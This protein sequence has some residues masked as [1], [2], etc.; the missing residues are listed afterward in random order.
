MSKKETIIVLSVGG[1]LVVPKNGIDV[2][3]LRELRSFVYQHT[4]KGK[5]FIIVVGGGRTA[6]QYQEAANA[7]VPLADEDV[8]WLGIHATRLNGHLLRSLFRDIALHRVVKDPTRKVVW[9]KKVLIAAG[10]KPGWS[11]DYVAV[12]MAKKFGSK[13]VIN[14]SN[15]NAVYDRDPNIDPDA[16]KFARMTWKQFRAIVGHE[17]HPGANHPFDPVASRLA[18]QARMTA[19]VAGKDLKNVSNIIDGKKFKG[20][21]I[22]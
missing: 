4:K 16:K 13:I 2:E 18:D 15:I 22:E 10:W 3:Y 19:I 8:D 11:T 21:V 7:L 20:T 14:L 9:N 1:S 17:W 6:R 5:R 12:K